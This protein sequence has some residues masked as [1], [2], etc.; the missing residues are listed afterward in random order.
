MSGWRAMF[1]FQEQAVHE[2]DDAEQVREHVKILCPKCG[3]KVAAVLEWAFPDPDPA[4]LRLC[5]VGAAFHVEYRHEG[6]TEIAKGYGNPW[7]VTLEQVAL[8]QTLGSRKRAIFHYPFTA[9]S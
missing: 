6:A 4:Y 5:P 9:L 1:E 2:M 3:H 8:R 7:P